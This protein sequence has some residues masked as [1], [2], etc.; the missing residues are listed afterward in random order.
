MVAALLCSTL[1]GRS[2]SQRALPAPP[3]QS[4]LRQDPARPALTASVAHLVVHGVQPEQV[5]DEALIDSER[6]IVVEA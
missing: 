4:R 3:L 2:P 6:V 1:R 5:V